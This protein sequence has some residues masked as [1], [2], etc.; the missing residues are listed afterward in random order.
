[1]LEETNQ[2]SYDEVPYEMYSFP[3]THPNRLSVIGQLFGMSPVPVDGCRVLE[4][5]CAQGGNLI[6]MAF[7]FPQSVFVGY[8][9]SSNQIEVGKKII[10]EVKINNITLK[11][12]DINDLND[13]EGEFDYIIVHG[14]YSWVPENVR[15][16][17][18]KICSQSLNPQGIAYISYNTYPG[19]R[20]KSMIRDMMLFHTHSIKE[21]NEKAN[22]ARAL[23]A[24]LSEA[25]T[26][27]KDPYGIFLKN[28][29][30]VLKKYPNSYIIHEMLEGVNEPCYFYEFNQRAFKHGLKYL[31]EADFQS[32]LKSNFPP[33]AIEVLKKIDKSII[34][35]EQY[36]DFLRN[37]QFRQT[38]LCHESVEIKRN[39]NPDLV[40]D[41][42][43]YTEL[44]PESENINLEEG[45]AYTFTGRKDFKLIL[46]NRL[47]KILFKYLS[48]LSPRAVKFSKIIDYLNQS[49][50]DNGDKNLSEI[51]ITALRDFIVQCYIK[52]AIDF[53]T[54]E[55]KLVNKISQYPVT[56]PLA[57]FQAQSG[58]SVTNEHHASKKLDYVIQ[59]IIL[60]LD[61]NNDVKAIG[62]K[63]LQ[64]TETGELVFK[65]DNEAIIDREMIKNIIDDKLEPNIENLA[66][67]AYLIG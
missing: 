37:R 53:N 47:A 21:P 32:M 12:A 20:M 14:T 7:N 13:K 28:E 16:K 38:L 3:Q 23:I 15:E 19:W 54:V 48:E 40:K 36:M 8:D 4:L 26:S 58:L 30:E 5:G 22:Q 2:I 66:K 42:Y 64:M 11:Q 55:I 34:A 1:M 27:E 43:I 61:G 60:L 17:I 29:L 62:D 57:R 25:A 56:S 50:N 65:K 39:I 67:T 33:K 24:F 41:F 49:C 63:L 52:K 51:D 6:P 44:K 9:L 59:R 46:K 31:G 35:T 10:D 45:K 18:L